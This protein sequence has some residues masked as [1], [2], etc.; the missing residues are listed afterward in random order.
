MKRLLILFFLF[1]VLLFAQKKVDLG[2][3]LGA[4]YYQGELNYSLPGLELHKAYGVIYRYNLHQRISFRFNMI[5]TDLSGND[6]HTMVSYWNKT[7]YNYQIIRNKSFTTPLLDISAQAEFNFK[8]Y[9]VGNDKYPQSPYLFAGLSFIIASYATQ[10]YLYG[11]PFGVGYKFNIGERI[12]A[13]VEWG[14]RKTFNDGIDKTTGQE[15]YPKIEKNPY[16]K[17]L[18]KQRGNFR[19]TDWYSIFGVFITYKFRPKNYECLMLIY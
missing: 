6:A 8:R 15:Q 5:F 10:P 9:E 12:G 13:G 18:L 2:I 1:P 11:I 4:A 16:S 7:P 19:N 17:N 3:F 14:Y